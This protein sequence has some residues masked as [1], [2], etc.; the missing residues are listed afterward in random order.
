[1]SRYGIHKYSLSLMLPP[2]IF[3]KRKYKVQY[4]LGINLETKSERNLPNEMFK[5]DE[6]PSCLW[7]LQ[8]HNRLRQTST[9]KLKFLG[10][11]RIENWLVAG[12][13]V[14]LSVISLVLARCTGRRMMSIS[15]ALNPKWEKKKSPDTPWQLPKPYNCQ[16][17]RKH[18]YCLFI[19]NV[20]SVFQSMDVGIIVSLKRK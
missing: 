1:M 16:Q 18:W 2:D 15:K 11:K 4:N 6:Q 8:R 7:S 12:I 13:P 10:L 20:T 19:P 5:L 17:V 9:W 14:L 3:I